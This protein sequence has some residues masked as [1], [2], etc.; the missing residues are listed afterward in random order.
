M[1]GEESGKWAGV[2]EMASKC[3]YSAL[4]ASG[5]PGVHEGMGSKCV[6]AVEKTGGEPKVAEQPLLHLGRWTLEQKASNVG[7]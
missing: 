7:R 1:R 2:E 3:T 5:W 6:R 4:E